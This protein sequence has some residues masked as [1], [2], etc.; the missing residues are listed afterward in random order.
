MQTSIIL[1]AA[2]FTILGILVTYFMAVMKLRGEFMK[3]KE[4]QN[5]HIACNDAMC[6]K[7]DAN[8]G[9]TQAVREELSKGTKEFVFF[10]VALDLIAEA[11]HIPDEK[12]EKLRKSVMD[13][14]GQG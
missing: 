5:T 8:I 4:F 12:L 9:A 1:I 10:R 11:L 13:G 6:K 2:G 3:K 14:R 7:L